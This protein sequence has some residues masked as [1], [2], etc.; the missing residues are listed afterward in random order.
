[1]SDYE[2][3]S[4][5]WMSLL[6]SQYLDNTE[7][8]GP[9]VSAC[10]KEPGS[11]LGRVRFVPRSVV[12]LMA[13]SV[14]R[15]GLLPKA[16]LCYSA[17]WGW[18]GPRPAI[19]LGAEWSVPLEK[20][21]NPATEWPVLMRMRLVSLSLLVFVTGMAPT[22]LCT[23]GKCCVTERHPYPPPHLYFY[24]ETG[25]CQVAPAGLEPAVLPR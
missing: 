21:Q 13:L 1:M 12:I 11:H 5:L 25:P 17:A 15:C 14:S 19:P 6:S 3:D 9:S 7:A 10:D 23:P 4:T 18:E 20:P 22:A 16:K 24:F 2:K 8:W